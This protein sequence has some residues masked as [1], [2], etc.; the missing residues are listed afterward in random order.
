MFNLNFFIYDKP[1][2]TVIIRQGPVPAIG[3][4]I[5]IE[6]R[7]YLVESRIWHYREPDF[8]SITLN[9]YGSWL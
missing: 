2:L 7:L 8:E 1:V 3:D 6:G 5:S 9:I 4:Q